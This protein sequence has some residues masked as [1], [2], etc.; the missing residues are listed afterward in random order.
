MK[1]T[2]PVETPSS[3]NGQDLRIG[4][5]MSR[6]N[7]HIGDGLLSACIE[8][9]QR[10]GVAEDAI[11]LATVPG[12]LEIPLALQV[13]ARSGQFDGLVAL[14][15][16]IRGETYHFE[17]VANESGAGI[18]RVGLDQHLPIA[19]AVLTTEDEDQALV[20]MHDKGREAAQVA[21]EMAQLQKIW[22]QKVSA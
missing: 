16:I 15:A 20:R 19:N 6:F 3:L 18:T 13:L 12:A 9:L 1:R 8:E 5:V 22:S 7:Q 14:G 4:L 17:L 2:T 11:H 10:L 21:V